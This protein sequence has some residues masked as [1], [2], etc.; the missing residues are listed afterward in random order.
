M[1]IDEAA[2]LDHPGRPLLGANGDICVLD[3]GEPVRVMD[4][5]QSLVK[6]TAPHIDIEVTQLRAGGEAL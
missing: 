1:T 6:A 2:Q 3:M 4:L 5:A